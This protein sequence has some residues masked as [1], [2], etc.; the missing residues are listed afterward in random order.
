[1]TT[2]YGNQ[3][4]GHSSGDGARAR[5]TPRKIGPASCRLPVHTAMSRLEVVGVPHIWCPLKKN[6][7]KFLKLKEEVTK[8]PQGYIQGHAKHIA[9][10]LTPNH[11]A[12]KC[13][14]A[15]GRER[16]E[17]CCG[18]VGHNCVGDPALETPGILPSASGAKVAPHA[19]IDPDYDAFKRG[20][21]TD[22]PRCPP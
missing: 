7:Q 22:P 20:T 21:T 19:R 15:F 11:K 1:M 6:C 4:C 13:L 5:G 3:E 8:Q 16:L 12:V 9:R 2:R 18:G 10:T 14:M 17:V